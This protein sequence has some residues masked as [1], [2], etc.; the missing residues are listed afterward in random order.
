MI[1][2]FEEKDL[3]AV[4]ALHAAQGLNYAF[5]DLSNPLWF[6]KFVDER[7]GKI[8]QAVLAHLTAEIY[9]MLDKTWGT[10]QDR[11]LAFLEVMDE[12]RAI[13]WHKGLEDLQA[14]L[15]PQVERAFGKR[16]CA[17]GWR[18]NVWPLYS[19]EL[20]GKTDGR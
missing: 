5:P 8:V 12:G 6:V 15:P 19:T 13:G 20:K 10:P 14:L 7:E 18:K 9:F 16:L 17:H 11:H 1:R 3:A 2:A 4:K